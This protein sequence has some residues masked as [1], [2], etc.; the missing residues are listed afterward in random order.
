VIDLVAGDAG[1]LLGKV[2]L[3]LGVCVWP[4]DETVFE[5]VQRRLFGGTPFESDNSG[6]QRR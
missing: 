4:R 3:L 2:G 1:H 5:D 6:E